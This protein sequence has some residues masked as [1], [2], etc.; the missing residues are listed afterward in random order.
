MSF[1]HLSSNL[2]LC[3][4]LRN[5]FPKTKSAA[6]YVSFALSICEEEGFCLKHILS[7]VDDSNTLIVTAALISLKPQ[8]FDAVVE[9]A[10]IARENLVSCSSSAPLLAAMWILYSVLRWESS[11]H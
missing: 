7:P 2:R 1:V 4:G 8:T 5:F 3:Q 11:Q 6:Y 10:C 9:H